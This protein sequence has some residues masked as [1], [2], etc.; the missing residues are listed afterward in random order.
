[1]STRITAAEARLRSSEPAG[2][3]QE[4]SEKIIQRLDVE[5]NKAVEGR[6]NT[7][8]DALNLVTVN[9]PEKSAHDVAVT[10]STKCSPAVVTAI[11]LDLTSRGFTIKHQ[12]TSRSDPPFNPKFDICW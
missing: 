1:M 2:E 10:S 12:T 9:I 3:D 11:T 4:I 8:Y 7:V 6:R 5:I